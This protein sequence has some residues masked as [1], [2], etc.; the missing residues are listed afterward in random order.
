MATATGAVFSGVMVAVV[1]AVDVVVAVAVALASG[2]D[3]ALP[4]PSR[5]LRPRLRYV[6]RGVPTSGWH[7]ALFSGTT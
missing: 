5:L 2:A 3:A 6:A 1:A 4:P 7:V